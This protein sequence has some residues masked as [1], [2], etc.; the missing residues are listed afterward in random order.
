MPSVEIYTMGYCPYCSAAKRLLKKL[1][2]K[3]N[4]IEITG[5]PKLKA[6]MVERT[7]RKTVPQ[8]FIDDQHIGGFDDFSQYVKDENLI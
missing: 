5:K 2:W 7:K 3:F 4:E 6:T 1:G 8:I